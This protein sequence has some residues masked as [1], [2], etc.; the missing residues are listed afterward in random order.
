LKNLTFT[1]I[2]VFAWT[3]CSWAQSP[4]PLSPLQGGEDVA[5]AFVLTGPLPINSYGTTEGFLDDYNEECGYEGAGA[6]D[7]VYSFSPQANVT[8]DIDLCGSSYDT[9][10]FIYENSVTPGFP[11][12]CNDDF[13]YDFDCGFFVSKIENL[14]LEAGNTYYIVIDGY[15]EDSYGDY[16]LTISETDPWQCTWGVELVCPVWALEENEPCGMDE[17]GGC[18]MAFGTESWESVPADGATFVAQAGRMAV[19][20]TP[21]GTSW[22]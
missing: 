2:L 12:A 14:L 6:P 18:D 21:T 13:Y 20:A 5:S 10:L 8:A 15:I 19:S 4:G 9:R 3:A 22:C 1:I 16:L 17:N 11:F 7:V